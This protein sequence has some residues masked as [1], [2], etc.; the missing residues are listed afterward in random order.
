MATN[1]TAITEGRVLALNKVNQFTIYL[2]A[3]L[4]CISSAFDNTLLM[5]VSFSNELSSPGQHEK[6]INNSLTKTFIH[7][8]F[9]D[10]F[11]FLLR[12]SI[13]GQAY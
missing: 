4:N 7:S 9:N 1:I 11:I 3:T 10:L 12:W 5:A 6:D 13:G 2:A 8:P